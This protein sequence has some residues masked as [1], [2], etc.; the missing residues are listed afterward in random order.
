MT[1]LMGWPLLLSGILLASIPVVIHLLHRQRTT[2]IRWGAMRF[3]LESPMRSRRRRRVDQWLLLAVRVAALL[4]LA[5]VLARPAITSGISASLGSDAPTDIAFVV[6][7]SLSMTRVAGDQTLFDQAAAIVDDSIRTLKRGDTLSIILAEHELRAMS[8]VP[9]PAADAAKLGQ[10][11]RQLKPGTTDCSIPAAVG[12]ARQILSH[13]PNSRKLVLILSDQQ[14][15]NWQIGDSGAWRAASGSS[16]ET[17]R[18][19]IYNVPLPSPKSAANISIGAITVEPNLVG[20]NRP[21]QILAAISNHGSTD[22]TALSIRMAVDGREAGTPMQIPSLPVGQSVTVRFDHTFTLAG[23]H[24]VKIWMDAIDALPADNL[25]V[26][27]ISVWQRL[28]VLIID[29]QLTRA[30]SFPSAQ[31]LAAAMQPLDPAR[32]QSALIVPTIVSA[33]DSS[34]AN[35]DDF[36]AVVINDV[37]ELPPDAEQRLADYAADGHGVWVILGPRTRAPFISGPQQARLAKLSVK[38][39]APRSAPNSPAIEIRSPANPMIALIAS[40]DRSALAGAATMKW[41]PL[42]AEDGDDQIILATADGDP[43]IL[44]HPVGNNGGRAV[45]WATSADGAWNNWNLMPNFVPLVNETIYHLCAPILR[46]QKNGS[47]TAGSPILWSGPPKPALQSADVTL[48]DGT[49]DRDRK[50]TFRSGQWEFQYPNTFEPGLYQVK[51]TA[52]G[53]MPPVYFGVGIDPRE[54]EPTVLSEQ[55]LLWLG[56]HAQTQTIHAD[57]IAAAIARQPGASEIW[58]WLAGVLLLSLLL[59]TALTWQMMGKQRTR[60]DVTG[61]ANRDAA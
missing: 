51:F 31:F 10:S 13:G 40:S 8:P 41:W 12:V 32:A 44:E 35:L 26:A 38:E 28:P 5:W 1:F 59:E 42:R 52:S 55:D 24:W 23:S 60:A 50:P 2:P 17:A 3:L 7:H 21:S 37:P 20:I 6:D 27:A 22:F 30:G 49:I 57:Q 53:A 25:A 47:I 9:A 48:P 36:Y 43:L 61:M 45:I 4:L 18:T 54:L 39:P 34:S 58:K 14:R 15:T 33:A 46:G 16:S 56:D 19:S 11:L 29:G